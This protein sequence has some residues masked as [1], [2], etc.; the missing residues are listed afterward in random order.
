M[1]SLKVTLNDETSLASARSVLKNEYQNTLDAH[2]FG[3][4]SKYEGSVI[5]KFF[6]PVDDPR[7]GLFFSP[8]L[9]TLSN[10]PA[11][12]RRRVL[13]VGAFSADCIIRLHAEKFIH[14]D[15]SV[16]NIVCQLNAAADKIKCAFP[17]DWA[18]M[19]KIGDDLDRE[20]MTAT[21]L[22]VSREVLSFILDS[23]SSLK[24]KEMH[25]SE[26]LFSSLL[27][28]LTRG[29]CPLFPLRGHTSALPDLHLLKT[30]FWGQPLH[31]QRQWYEEHGLSELYP[32]HEA[33]VN[34]DARLCLSQLL[35]IARK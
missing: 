13:A 12:H 16:N 33:I 1:G 32:A 9:I 11:N 30:L 21:P 27:Y 6:D 25:D 18:T 35:K 15:L 3:I 7:V 28:Q 8:V 24:A 34:G 29:N 10:I 26:T 14:G 22:F 20:N 2:S 23:R 19:T 5:I 4:F 17:I 31:T